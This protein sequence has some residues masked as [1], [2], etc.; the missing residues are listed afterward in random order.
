MKQT[1]YLDTSVP[2]AYFDDNN[3]ERQKL[4]KRFWE[5]L[6]TFDIF[7]SSLALF[8]VEKFKDEGK[9]RKILALLEGVEE[10]TITEE[11][12]KLADEYVSRGIFPNKYRDDAVHVAVAVVNAMDYLVI[13]NILSK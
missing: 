7:I 2:S 13:L 12:E 1:I 3:P 9:K 5:K 4:T 8:E 10:L 6:S 11:C